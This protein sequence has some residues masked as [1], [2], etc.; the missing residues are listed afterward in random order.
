MFSI[1][2]P[3]ICLTAVVGTWFQ[4]GSKPLSAGCF[5]LG[6]LEGMWGRAE[7]K[8]IWSLGALFTSQE[9]YL[10]W[11]SCCR[12]QADPLLAPVLLSI[13][14]C[15]AAAITEQPSLGQ[16]PCR[17]PILTF[18]L[19]NYRLRRILSRF[20]VNDC[21]PGLLLH[22]HKLVKTLDFLACTFDVSGQT[23]R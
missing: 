2:D 14:S 4:C 18:N 21:A 9:V 12:R 1:D 16:N 11:I 13:L 22:P 3:S 17:C 15:W 19:Q 8:M 20:S 6:L 23:W 5:V 10:L 7:C